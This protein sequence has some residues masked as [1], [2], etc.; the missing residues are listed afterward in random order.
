MESPSGVAAAGR[1]ASAGAVGH[2]AYGPQKISLASL[3]LMHTAQSAEY[4]TVTA[5]NADSENRVIFP[6]SPTERGGSLWWISPHRKWW[7]M[8]EYIAK[9]RN[10]AQDGNS[11]VPNTFDN[12]Y[13]YFTEGEVQKLRR[14]GWTVTVIQTC[15]K[16]DDEG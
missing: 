4:S 3:A 1:E 7:M 2:M 15:E 14:A 12:D 5:C 10:P 16:D 8:N 11:P 9:V 6:G 13:G